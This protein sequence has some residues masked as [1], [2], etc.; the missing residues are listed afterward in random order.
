M[1]IPYFYLLYHA[2]YEAIHSLKKIY[3]VN[4][5]IKNNSVANSDMHKVWLINIAYYLTAHSSRYK[6]S[7]QDKVVSLILD[8]LLLKKVPKI[9][10]GGYRL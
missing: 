4:K 3:Q 6:L 2:K 7:I 9:N 5:L 8:P 1:F 10:I